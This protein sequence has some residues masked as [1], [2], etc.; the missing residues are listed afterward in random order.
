MSKI[1][2]IMDNALCRII[3]ER[4]RSIILRNVHNNF[5]KYRK[6][7]IDLADLKMII[8]Y[9]HQYVFE[10]QARDNYFVIDMKTVEIT[11]FAKERSELEDKLSET[12]IIVPLPSD[13]S[14]KY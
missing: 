14:Y 4:D 12:E 11:A 2:E 5:N 13:L 10:N 9:A 3:P 7:E 6:Y 8:G 1:E